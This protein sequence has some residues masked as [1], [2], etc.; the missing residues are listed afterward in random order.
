MWQHIQGYI[1]QEI[2]EIMEG[3]YQKLNKH[4]AEAINLLAAEFYI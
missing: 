2:R 4:Q 1:D 3:L